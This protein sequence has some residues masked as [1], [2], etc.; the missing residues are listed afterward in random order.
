MGDRATTP[1]LTFVLAV[2]IT[3][4]LVSGLL[5]TSSGFV[6][7]RRERAV[8]EELA[9][10]GER[11]SAVVTAVDR[12]SESGGAVS[13]RVAVPQRVVDAPYYVDVVNCSAGDACLELTTADPAFD[14]AVRVPL[15]NR[16]EVAVGR[17]SSL[18][19]S[20]ESAAGTD[21]PP[22]ADADA[23]VAPNLGVSSEVRAGSGTSGSILG[24]NQAPVVPGFDYDPSPPAMGETIGFT[25]DVGNSGAGNL[26]YRWD[27]DGDGTF[28]VTGNETAAATATH[29][30]AAPGRYEA[31]L[32]VEDVAG[33]TDNVTRL[34]RVSGL[35][36]AGNR[37][38]VDTDFGGEKAGVQFDVRNNFGDEEI[39]VTEVLVDPAD[40]D[41]TYLYRSSGA[42][43]VFLTDAGLEPAA[44]GVVRVEDSGS[45]ADFG[46]EVTLGEDGL[47]TVRM[48][49][50]LDA[51]GDQVGMFDEDVTVAFRYEIAGTRR[52][53]VSKFDID[54]DFVAGVGDPP[55]V[56]AAEANRGEEYVSLELSD[57]NGDLDTV[58]VEVLDA[59]GDVVVSNAAG[60]GGDSAAG[61]LD[62]DDEYPYHELEEGEEVRVTV[63]DL[64]GNTNTTR[65]SV[66]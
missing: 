59:D 2:G 7:D 41:L 13:R 21:P 55:S 19:V 16:S 39:A 52:N 60:I 49:E 54:T 66:T 20:I 28:D 37:S 33:A 17:P 48:G 40:P 14:V 11:I 42:E 22:A 18:S 50:F 4:L 44:D 38:V 36:F 25:A 65:V 1:A 5:I 46:S 9:V 3:A 27:F 35:V 23:E 15:D 47:A 26:T 8:R 12:A 56:D 57:P 45:I 53:Y 43:V 64:E 58:T 34:V 6:E 29:T 61:I 10:V 30:Y 31:R 24:A 51:D 62:V 63:T 32:Q